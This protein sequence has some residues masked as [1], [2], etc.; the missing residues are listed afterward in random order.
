MSG[1]GTALALVAIL[2]G[3]ALALQSP[4]VIAAGWPDASLPKELERFFG[5]SDWPGLVATLGEIVIIVLLLLAM[6]CVSVGRRHLGA[7]HLLRAVLGLGGILGAVLLFSGA[8]HGQSFQEVA[9]MLKSDQIGPAFELALGAFHP[10]RATFAGIL[11]GLSVLVL[12][13][14]ARRRQNAYVALPNQGVS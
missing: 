8:A 1:V 5:Y 12:A 2:L 3:L 9:E 6:I 4:T 11:F 13:W 10:G 14:P 7:A